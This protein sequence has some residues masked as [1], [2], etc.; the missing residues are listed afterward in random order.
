M[1]ASA[2]LL[3]AAKIEED[4]MVKTRDVVNVGYRLLDHPALT[5]STSFSA[6]T[7]THK[8]IFRTF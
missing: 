4:E 6:M 2:C 7:V 1:I 5:F 3:L 8:E